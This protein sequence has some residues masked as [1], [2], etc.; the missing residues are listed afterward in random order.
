WEDLTVT[1]TD[2]SVFPIGRRLRRESARDA[3]LRR[4]R[5]FPAERMLGL[6]RPSWDGLVLDYSFLA[7][8]NAPFSGG[9][10]GAAL[11]PDAVGGSRGLRLRRRP[12]ALRR[13]AADPLR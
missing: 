11:G 2:P 3:F 4:G 8:S 13:G 9:S 7:P 6:E 5:G 10:Y 12:G 1:F